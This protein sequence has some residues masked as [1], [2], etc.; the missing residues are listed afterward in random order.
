MLVSVINMSVQLITRIQPTNLNRILIMKHDVGDSQNTTNYLF[1]TAGVQ[2]GKQLHVSALSSG[3][4]V[5]HFTLHAK[6]IVGAQ[7]L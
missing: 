2:D 3:H 5:Y 6:M 7:L 4:L 1:A